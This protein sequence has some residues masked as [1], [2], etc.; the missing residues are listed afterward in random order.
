VAGTPAE[1]QLSKLPK[2]PG[3]TQIAAEKFCYIPEGRN[4]SIEDR[5]ALSSSTTKSAT[6][7]EPD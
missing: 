1:K 6:K 2:G 7:P 5:P 4:E 3:I